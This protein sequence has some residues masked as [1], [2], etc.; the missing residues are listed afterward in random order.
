[1][2]R[3][4]RNGM[5]ATALLIVGLSGAGTLFAQQNEQGEAGMQGGMQGGMHGNMM[6]MMQQ[7]NAMMEQCSAMMDGMH[8]Q[9]E[10]E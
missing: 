6:G 5:I 2:M 1:M 8:G 4:T 7:M 3:K 10:S 9:D